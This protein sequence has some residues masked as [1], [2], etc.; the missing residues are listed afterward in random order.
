[1]T[2]EIKSWRTLNRPKCVLTSCWMT[3]SS[4][5]FM[6]ARHVSAGGDH[7]T[8]NCLMRRVL[9]SYGTLPG[10]S[11]A[12]D[13]CSPLEGQ[14]RT[15]GEWN[16]LFDDFANF[17]HS[18]GLYF[19]TCVHGSLF[20]VEGIH[21]HIFHGVFEWAKIRISSSDASSK[22]RIERAISLRKALVRTGP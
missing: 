1:M 9:A 12:I 7:K 20:W 11:Q 8:V 10:S 22:Y 16:Q 15:R 19:L 14:T 6:D 21:Q 5:S 3:L 4:T 2:Y 13:L 18:H 17:V